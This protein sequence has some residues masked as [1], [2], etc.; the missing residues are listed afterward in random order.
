M[1][2]QKIL[3]ILRHAKAETGAPH[4]EDHD[5]HLTDR[6]EAAA[7]AMGA[8]FNQQ[9]VRLDQVL[10]ST[11]NRARETWEQVAQVFSTSAQVEYS[12][13][14]YLASVNET[15]QLL[16]NAD[17][18]VARLLIVG[19]NPGLHQFCLKFAKSG[20]ISLMDTLAIKFPTCAF[21][22][23]ALGDAPWRD[24]AHTHGELKAFVTPSMLGDLEE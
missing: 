8:F 2:T 23:I 9:G 17:E 5:R 15:T 1:S 4:Q 21:A 14:L 19:H 18:Q 12:D 24:L 13:R 7:R 20:P 16:A 22:A 3:Y 10:C 6:G 11:A